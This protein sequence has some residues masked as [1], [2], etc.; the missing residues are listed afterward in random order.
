MEEYTYKIEERDGKFWAVVCKTKMLNK[1]VRVRRTT[2]QEEGPFDSHGEADSAGVK[3][4]ERF[5][6]LKAFW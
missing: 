6:N 1:G 4:R 2:T 5:E 3:L